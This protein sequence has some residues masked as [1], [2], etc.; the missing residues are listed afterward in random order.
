MVPQVPGVVAWLLAS[1]CE[2]PPLSPRPEHRLGTLVGL[3]TRRKAFCF[4]VCEDTMSVVGSR[5]KGQLPGSWNLV[6]LRGN[7]SWI[8]KSRSK[9]DLPWLSQ[10]QRW[11][12]G[13]PPPSEQELDRQATHTSSRLWEEGQVAGLSQPLAGRPSRLPSAQA[14]AG[15]SQPSC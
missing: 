9:R 8:L 15:L 6:T 7:V 5:V 4:P 11:G 12:E 2:S 1:S 3:P 13:P 14:F 10:N